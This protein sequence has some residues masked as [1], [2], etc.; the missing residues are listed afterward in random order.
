MGDAMTNQTE[1][2]PRYEYVKCA[3]CGEVIQQIDFRG[4][5]HAAYCANPK[6]VAA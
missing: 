3:T 5:P 1:N 4:N 2:D 6:E